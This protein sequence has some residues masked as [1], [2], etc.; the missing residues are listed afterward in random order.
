MRKTRINHWVLHSLLIVIVELENPSL[1]VNSVEVHLMW[2]Y[3]L[4]TVIFKCTE[5]CHVL[6]WPPGDLLRTIE[7]LCNRTDQHCIQRLLTHKY[8]WEIFLY[9]SIQFHSISVVITDNLAAV[10]FSLY[11][12]EAFNE[13][14][15]EV[16]SCGVF[17]VKTRVLGGNL[18]TIPERGTFS[19]YS[20]LV[21]SHY[22]GVTM[23]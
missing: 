12:L 22:S 7:T 20:Y 18:M 6:T 10:L 23:L 11:M 17:V 14:S 21:L 1:G 15:Q 2:M 19:R 16:W 9:T 8:L 13:Q 4:Q 3:L 5:L